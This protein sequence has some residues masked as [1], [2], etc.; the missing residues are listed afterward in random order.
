M[1]PAYQKTIGPYT[2]LGDS[3]TYYQLDR[4]RQNSDRFNFSVQRQLPT[5]MVVDVTYYINRSSF[6]FDT[7][8]NLNM[9]RSEHRVQI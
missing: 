8:R 2:Q 3:T 4:P 7:T 1:Q 5:G 6:I 9:S